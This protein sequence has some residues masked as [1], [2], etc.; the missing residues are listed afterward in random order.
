MNK[1]RSVLAGAVLTLGTLEVTAAGARAYGAASFFLELDG[2]KSGFFKSV[3]GGAISAEVIESPTAHGINKS[4]GAPQ[5]EEFV[6]RHAFSGGVPMLNW[7]SDFFDGQQAAH[8]G[9]IIAADFNLDEKSRR[10]FAGALI[11]EVSIPACDG[12]S[13]EPAFMTVKFSPEVIKNQ[14]SK[15]GKLKTD[16]KKQ[17]QWLPSNFRLSLPGVDATGVVRI[18]A[19]TVKQPSGAEQ[20]GHARLQVKEPGK[21]EYPNLRLSISAA[22]ANDF[23]QWHE[24]FVIKGN[25]SEKPEG[26]LSLL[27]PDLSEELARVSLKN[28]GIFRLEPSSNSTDAIAT[29]VVDLYVEKMQID[30]MT[31]FEK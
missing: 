8:E 10:S 2:A 16:G 15:G 28:I 11:T 27:A 1:L 21:V 25:S 23:I 5:Y 18:E 29:V 12:S 9:A 6:V 30:F 24:D 14:A 31:Q 20:A 7:I 13:K 17:K 3:D 19:F 4:I 22:H 26:T